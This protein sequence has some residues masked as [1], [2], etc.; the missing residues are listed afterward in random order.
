MIKPVY[1]YIYKP[2]RYFMGKF[3]FPVKVNVSS[4]RTCDH[5]VTAILMQLCK[6]LENL[7]YVA[8]LLR[9]LQPVT[10]AISYD[11]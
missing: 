5:P 8:T 10:N 11:H 9:L 4:H 2:W 1:I 3:V 6:N 7:W